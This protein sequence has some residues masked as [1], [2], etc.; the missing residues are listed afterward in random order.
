MWS[1]VTEKA[2]NTKTRKFQNLYNEQNIYFK[3][4]P[5]IPKIN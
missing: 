4:N 2:G 3:Q 5:K 1:W